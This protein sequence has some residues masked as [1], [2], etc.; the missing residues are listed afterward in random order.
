MKP[1]QVSRCGA[2]MLTSSARALCRAP[3]WVICTARGKPVEP[4]VSCRKAVSSGAA[5]VLDEAGG[6]RRRERRGR[7]AVRQRRLARRLLG[8][9]PG[10]ALGR[11]D[12]RGRQVVDD[13]QQ[14]V[15]LHPAGA[16]RGARRRRDRQRAQQD[17]AEPGVEPLERGGQG[18]DD[19]VARY[20]RRAPPAGRRSAAPIAGARRRCAGRPCG[21]VGRRPSGRC[22]GA[23]CAPRARASGR[24][25]CCSVTISAARQV[26]AGSGRA[27][28][29]PPRRRRRCGRSPARRPRPAASPAAAA[30]CHCGCWNG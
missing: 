24:L 11:D 28:R 19:A 14:L 23:S 22:S 21:R 29:R 13:A 25:R 26:Y 27:G 3:P 7:D 6:D 4:L 10:Q 18:D 17:R 20:E 30:A 8:E 15:Q 9:L 16:D 1:R 5:G 2:A 12:E